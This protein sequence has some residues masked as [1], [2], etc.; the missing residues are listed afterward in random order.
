M[1]ENYLLN[2]RAIAHVVSNLE[3]FSE[4]PFEADDIDTWI[5]NHKFDPKY[6]SSVSPNEL[7]WRTEVHGAK[8]LNDMFLELSDKRYEYDKLAYGLELT[9]WL[10]SNEPREL[11]EVA[12]ILKKNRDFKRRFVTLTANQR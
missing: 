9:K 10:V 7:I 3:D 8:L 12:E 4:N 11:K 5:K 2:S 6:Y 1:Y